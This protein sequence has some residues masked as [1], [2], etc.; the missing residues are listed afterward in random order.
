MWR[1]LEVINKFTQP[2]KASLVPFSN[3]QTWHLFFPYCEQNLIQK[4]VRK[5]LDSIYFKFSKKIIGGFQVKKEI[6]AEIHQAK[7]FAG[8]LIKNILIMQH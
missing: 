2:E 3:C 4:V 7:L 5:L 8:L 1:E 6:R